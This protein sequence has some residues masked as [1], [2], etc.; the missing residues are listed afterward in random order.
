MRGKMDSS[1]KREMGKVRDLVI[2]F[3]MYACMPFSSHSFKCEFRRLRIKKHENFMDVSERG[4]SCLHYTTLYIFLLF[5]LIFHQKK[6]YLLT[7]AILP[8]QRH[9]SFLTRR[10]C[11]ETW[12]REKDIKRKNVVNLSLLR[13]IKSSS[14]TFSWKFIHWTFLLIYWNWIPEKS[15]LYCLIF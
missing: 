10:V 11:R 1:K 13:E 7:Q 14:R 2:D 12:G 8:Q 6:L 4:S 15:N 3:N 9:F 5:S